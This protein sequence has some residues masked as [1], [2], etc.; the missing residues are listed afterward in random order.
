[1]T[2]LKDVA[3]SDASILSIRRFDRAVLIDYLGEAATIRNVLCHGSWNKK[4]DAEG[5]SIPFF[6]T[7]LEEK[8]RI[9]D[10]IDI[11]YL[12]QVQRGAAELA[13]ST[14]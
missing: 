5:R 4:P 2:Y 1:M 12:Q 3:P 14:L 10:P 9:F 8:Q 6:V 7:G 13:S 11:A